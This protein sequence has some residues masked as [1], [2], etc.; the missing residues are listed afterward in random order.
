MKQAPLLKSAASAFLVPAAIAVGLFLLAEGGCRVARRIRSGAWPATRAEAYTV[1]VRQ[2]GKAYQLHP[3]LVV[4][5]R[6]NAILRAAGKEVVFNARGERGTNVL[7]LAMPKPPG[8]FRIVCEGGSSTFDLL[9]ENNAATWPARLG[10]LL[11]GKDV[12]V[13]NAGFPGWTSLESLVS[14]EIRDVE[15]QPDLVVVMSGVNDLQPAGHE[16]FTPDY[17]AGH[18]EVLPRVTGAAPVPIRLVSR[19]LFL[20][21]L[22]DLLRPGRADAAEG[23]APSYSWTG[24]SRKDDIPPEAVA[25]YRRNLLSTIGVASAHGARVVLVPQVLRVRSDHALR[26]TRWIEGWCPGLTVAGARKGLERFNAEMRRLAGEGRAQLVEPFP[27]GGPPDADLGDPCHFSAAGSDR[28]AR[29][30]AEFVSKGVLEDPA[31]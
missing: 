10:T 5:G 9:A 17:S 14:L 6:P 16:P 12:D 7:D 3:M 28:F 31:R 30:L 1:F 26:D 23:F 20:E 13:A 15:V 21:S 18:L 11:A 19:S 24:G 4:S 2:V 25:A 22:L 8:R 29:R 27:D